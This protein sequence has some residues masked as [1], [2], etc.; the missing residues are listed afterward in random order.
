MVIDPDELINSEDANTGSR[1]GF[2]RS[3][4]PNTRMEFKNTKDLHLYGFSIRSSVQKLFSGYSDYV[5]DSYDDQSVKIG[6][7]SR[8]SCSTKA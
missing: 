1:L 7:D 3:A 4:C 5:P 2:F 6:D 8:Q